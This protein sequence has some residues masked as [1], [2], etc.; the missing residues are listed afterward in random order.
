LN[1]ILRKFALIAGFIVSSVSQVP[2]LGAACGKFNSYLYWLTSAITFSSAMHGLLCTVFVSVYG[3]GLALRGPVG[4]MVKAVD[5]MLQDQTHVLNTFTFTMA[6]FT[7]N[8]VS[9]Y[10]VMMEVPMAAICTVVTAF[11]IY[12]WYAILVRIYNRFK[13]KGMDKAVWNEEEE[14]DEDD[15]DKVVPLI[16]KDPKLPP[17]GQNSDKAKPQTGKSEEPPNLFS[18]M[19]IA[20]EYASNNNNSKGGKPAAPSVIVE[21]ALTE[22]VISPLQQ[23]MNQAAKNTNST[24]TTH[25]TNNSNAPRVGYITLKLGNG[26]IFSDPWKRV[27]LVVNGSMLYYYKDK[28]TY[29]TDAQDT[30]RR[31]AIDVKGMTLDCDVTNPPFKLTLHSGKDNHSSNSSISTSSA[32]TPSSSSN[33]KTSIEFRCDTANEAVGWMNRFKIAIS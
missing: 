2:A 1:S 23:A 22:E 26:S 19:G 21:S 6:L 4:S 5:G 20:P 18:M 24:N 16:S 31:R 3:Q 32:A 30:I 12:Y 28:L 15:V 11:G 13:F 27:Y 9:M 8:V 29:D 17:P 10:W 33:A 14:D 7:V 25:T